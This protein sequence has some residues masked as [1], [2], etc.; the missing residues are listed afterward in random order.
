MKSEIRPLQRVEKEISTDS[1]T[2]IKGRP[3][4][5]RVGS[6]RQQRLEAESSGL[7]PEQVPQLLHAF[8]AYTSICIYLRL[9]SFHK[10]L[11]LSLSLSLSQADARL[12]I[13]GLFCA[14]RKVRT[15]HLVV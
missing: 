10:L 2:H 14:T 11:Y 9:S 6:S 13:D 4:G 1:K 12:A 3:S 7:A 15:A 8:P 5:D